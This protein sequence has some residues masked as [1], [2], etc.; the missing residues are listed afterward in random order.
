MLSKSSS[1]RSTPYEINAT[2]TFTVASVPPF[3]ELDHDS[4]TII[5]INFLINSISSYDG[6]SFNS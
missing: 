4:Y 1:K 5:F 3:S 2:E 6:F